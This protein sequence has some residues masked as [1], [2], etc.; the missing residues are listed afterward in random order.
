MGSEVAACCCP[1]GLQHHTSPACAVPSTENTRRCGSSCMSALSCCSLNSGVLKDAQ[2]GAAATKVIKLTPH[3]RCL[4]YREQQ[5][6]PL[7]VSAR[8][9]NMVTASISRPHRW[10]DNSCAASSCSMSV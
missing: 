10:E 1:T 6:T 2:E 5:Q 3:R 9:T 7:T 4:H 8:P